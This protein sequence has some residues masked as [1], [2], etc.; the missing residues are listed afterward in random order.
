MITVGM[1]YRIREGKGPAFEKKFALVM[2]AMQGM[3]GHVNTRLYRDAHADR[4]Y[5][6]VS[7]WDSRSSFDAFV[8]SPEFARTTRWGRD[9]ILE[10]RPKHKVYEEG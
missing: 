3:S 5:M 8:A 9:A 7:E 10:G 6:V 1:N 4:H 2:S